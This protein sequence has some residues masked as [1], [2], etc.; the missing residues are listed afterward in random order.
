[1]SKQLHHPQKVVTFKEVGNSKG[2]EIAVL[3]TTNLLENLPARNIIVNL[4]YST[5]FNCTRRDVILDA[6]VETTPEL[7]QVVH[8]SYSC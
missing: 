2:V 7:H 5:A 1:M 6:V 4:T 8:V 3:V